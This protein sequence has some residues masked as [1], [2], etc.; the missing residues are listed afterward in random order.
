MFIAGLLVGSAGLLL[1]FWGLGAPSGYWPP[2]DGR[3]R[4]GYKY[5]R[6]PI[7]GD[8]R[9]GRR[10]I[11]IGLVLTAAFLYPCAVSYRFLAESWNRSTMDAVTPQSDLSVPLDM[12]VSA[13]PP[14]IRKRR[15]KK[16]PTLPISPP[17]M[18]VDLDNEDDL[19][20]FPERKR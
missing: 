6:E 16:T 8:P 1:V 13:A 12:S 3:Y 15:H 17:D 11:Q 19:A 4:T 18:C 14:R 9:A 2:R 5:N 10:H 20:T 7:P